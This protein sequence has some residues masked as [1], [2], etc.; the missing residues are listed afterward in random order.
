MWFP[1]DWVD[2]SGW[3]NIE[4]KREAVVAIVKRSMDCTPEEVF[5]VLL[6]AYLYPDWVVGAKSIRRVDDEWPS[7]GA[8]FYHRVGA[9][10]AEVKDKSEILELDSPRRLVLRTYARPAGIARVVLTASPNGNGATVAIDEQ[11][12]EGT[13]MRSFARFIDP[14]VHLRNVESLR[15]LEG[16]IKKESSPGT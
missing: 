7:V 13:R 11:P 3:I 6:D 8:A 12:E 15:R 10:A 5:E 4:G 9:G 2:A 14:A 1:S 16:V